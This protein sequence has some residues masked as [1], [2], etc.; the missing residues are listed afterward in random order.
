MQRILLFILINLAG[1][2]FLFAQNFYSL[3]GIIADK[4]SRKPI[5]YCTVSL[6]DSASSAVKSNTFSDENGKFSFEKIQSA[7][8][9]ISVKI[10]GY[11]P[12]NPVKIFINKST[13]LADT[14]F[15]EKTSKD[16]KE[17]TVTAQK[18][19][20]EIETD[21]TIYNVENDASLE[22]L[23]AIDALKKLPF[24]TVDAEDN[25][26]LKGS[27]NFKVLLNGKS[28]SI[29]AKNPKEALKAF[30]TK[31]IKKIEIMT[32]PSAKYDAEGTAGIINI[33]T[34][35]KIAGY[36]GNVMGSYSSRGM[37]NFGG[38]V[39]V[40]AGKFGFS[41]YFGGNYY[42]FQN[43]NSYEFFRN[44]LISAN[45]NLHQWGEYNNTGIWYWGNFEMSYDFDTLHSLSFY[46]TPGGGL[47]NGNSILNSENKDSAGNVTESF[48]NS[49]KND[50]NN[51]SY[52]IGFDFIKKFK[53][54]EE[55]ELT[56]S[57]SRENSFENSSFTSN[58]DYLILADNSIKNLNNSNNLE[59]SLRLDYNKPFKNK[60]K[61]E[62]GGKFI[63]RKLKSEYEM[64]Q[65]SDSTE[66]YF[67]VPAQ[68]NTLNYTQNVAGVYTTFAMMY[69]KIRIKP[70]LRLENT[71]INAEFNKDSLPIEINY[72]NLIPTLGISKK[73]GKK[74]TVRINYSRRIQRPW[75]QYLNPY[76]NN[77][78]P[79]SIKYGNPNLQ[80][81]KTNNVNFSYNYFFKRNSLDISLSN[82]FTDNVITSYTN[83]DSSGISYTTYLNIA[84]SNTTGIN[85]SLWG[86]FFD[87]MQVW[88]GVHSSYVYMVNKLDKTR[89]R[90]GFSH[91]GNGNITWNFK[92]DYSATFGGWIWQ[93]APTLQSTR[94]L[95]YNYNL[96]LRKSFFKK[97]LNVGLVANNFLEKKQTLK[98]ITEDPTFY[99]ESF[100]K[101]N[102]FRYYSVSLSFSFGKLKESV[103][104]K[105]GKG[106]DDLKG[107]ESE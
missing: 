72:F 21:K 86:M 78:D 34:Y 18:P 45:N 8:Y 23:M 57:L 53:D 101:N 96:S 30:P 65:K 102:F 84:K 12:N 77:M 50:N 36:N 49:S 95:N 79:K 44:S 107:K 68:T 81:E 19:L 35:K 64:S 32:E 88:V 43:Q 75:L 92:K 67:V 2:Q 106:D 69:K 1:I 31:L 71:W 103:S 15:I 82:S 3:K 87:K 16:L 76:V 48:L 93:G 38:S 66:E 59:Y 74:T 6:T 83:L 5:A 73:F 22:G 20:L 13:E 27:S 25:I 99:Q 89:N 104:R 97:K 52:D 85:V 14:I 80:P 58:R 60:S 105:K 55:H 7:L 98:T 9:F 11:K 61:F 33:I 46:V 63:S 37:N 17:V 4:D 28:T 70:G 54:N 41:S 42:E 91:R 56:L 94:P 100:N 51:P 39:N 62:A 47:A 29:I 24:I 90:S 40:K 10:A 26:Q